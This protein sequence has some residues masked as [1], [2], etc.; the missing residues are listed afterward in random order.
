M[1]G[2]RDF[3]LRLRPAGAPGAAAA[4]GVPADPKARAG[5][6]LEPVFAALLPV[7]AECRRL[8]SDAEMQAAAMISAAKE[9]ARTMGAQAEVAGSAERATRAANLAAQVEVEVARLAEDAQAEV[10]HVE[11]TAALRREGQIAQVLAHVRQR[12]SALDGEAG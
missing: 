9:Q 12:L 2:V 10:A 7:L 11:H 1:P 6:E 4:A 3:L 8:R 5:D